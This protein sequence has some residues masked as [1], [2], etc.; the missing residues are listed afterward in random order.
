MK[1]AAN[2]VSSAKVARLSK[3]VSDR[4]G[5]HFPP[6]RRRDLL[7]YTGAAVQPLGFDDLASCVDR[8]ISSPWTKAQIE[9]LARYLTV[10]ETYFFRHKRNFEILEREILPPLMR[11]RKRRERRLRLWSAACCSGEE[12]YSLAIVLERLIPDIEDWH[13]T[14]LAT[15]INPQF[16]HKAEEGIYTRWSFRESPEL[17]DNGKYF[18]KLTGKRVRIASRVKRM[19]QFGCLNLA[20]DT[21]PSLTNNTAA[22]DVILCRN[23]LIYFTPEQIEQ[24][25]RKLHRSLVDGGAL[26]VS[27]SEMA[28]VPASLFTRKQSHG[29]IHFKKSVDDAGKPEV[30]PSTAAAGKHP[31]MPAFAGV[32]KVKPPP[33]APLEVTRAEPLRVAASSEAF[34]DAPSAHRVM[35]QPAADEFAV[36]TGLYEQGHYVEAIDILEKLCASPAETPG[37]SRAS[38]QD[39]MTLLAR[40]HANAGQLEDAL[41]WC[42]KTIALDKLDCGT[43]YLEATIL[44]E[45]GRLEY[46]EKALRRVVYLDDGYALAHFALANLCRQKGAA[47]EANKHLQNALRLLRK[48]EPGEILEDADGMTVARLVTVIEAMVGQKAAA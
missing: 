30:T 42:G 36:A 35:E 37:V 26:I 4:M 38:M 48:H 29:A 45:L 9:I 16:L 11:A 24:V 8:L 18:T 14:I 12:P 1:G 25:I 27:G 7:S 33:V 22:M 6:D 2:S 13:I 44:Q 46:A 31:G 21:Y 17:L 20:S 41:E 3:L 32:V 43:H 15:D 39:K 40:A 19:V 10:G 23:V 47:A 28:M 34:K 5:L